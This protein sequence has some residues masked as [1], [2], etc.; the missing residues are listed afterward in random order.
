M[1]RFRNLIIGLGWLLIAGAVC[2]PAIAQQ[3][4]VERVN[5]SRKNWTFR[6][7]LVADGFGRGNVIRTYLLP[8]TGLSVPQ[9]EPSRSTIEGRD[10]QP[11]IGEPVGFGA[12]TV[13][14]VIDQNGARRVSIEQS[15]TTYETKVD[16]DAAAK[17]AWPE[18]PWGDDLLACLEPSAN[19][20]SDDAGVIDA[21][22][23]WTRRDPKRVNP[24]LLAKYLT[25]ETIDNFKADLPY[26]GRLERVSQDAKHEPG[27]RTG[28]R[29]V[30][31]RYNINGAA[32]VARTSSGSPYDLNYFLVAVMRACGLP[33]RVVVGIDTKRPQEE[34]LLPIHMWAEFFVPDGTLTDGVVTQANGEWVPVDIVKQ[35]AFSSQ[36]PLSRR[37]WPYFGNH[38]DGETLIPFAFSLGFE[39]ERG[40]VRER[41]LVEITVPEGTPDPGARTYIVYSESVARGRR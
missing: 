20:E 29:F 31:D 3:P 32:E 21:A 24:Y 33:A 16:E 39:G 30:A 22:M 4:L 13:E 1:H 14:T 11:S 34:F 40:E 23:T 38:L 9:A 2:T 8:E 35:M 7:D 36:A 26:H 10:V 17:R 18:A 28:M 12:R 15:H 37:A 25:G 27:A 5:S 19:I 41:D 6:L